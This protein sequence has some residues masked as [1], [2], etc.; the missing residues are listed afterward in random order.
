MSSNDPRDDVRPLEK[1]WSEF[2]ASYS[3][4]RLHGWLLRELPEIE[5]EYFLNLRNRV[6]D[7]ILHG[8]GLRDAGDGDPSAPLQGPAGRNVWFWDLHEAYD[9]EAQLFPFDDS[10]EDYRD[11]ARG[12]VIVG[13]HS[14]LEAYCRALGVNRPH[15]PL[16]LAIQAALKAKGRDLDA[17]NAQRLVLYDETRHLYV[18]HRGTVTQQYVDSVLYNKLNVSERRPVTD[19]DVEEFAW[20]VWKV[21]SLLRDVYGQPMQP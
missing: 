4:A 13:L 6:V 17:Q 11:A 14:A 8:E 15:T 1:D 9:L 19:D 16:P 18:H 3:A 21:A 2:R 10:T 12:L 7:A 20:V 5:P